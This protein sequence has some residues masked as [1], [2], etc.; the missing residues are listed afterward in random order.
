MGHRKKGGL[1]GGC[2]KQ[3]EE[4]NKRNGETKLRLKVDGIMKDKDSKKRK[5][6]EIQEHKKMEIL[7]F[8]L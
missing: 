4:A 1:N 3:E 7:V 8:D 5:R 6:K 2:I